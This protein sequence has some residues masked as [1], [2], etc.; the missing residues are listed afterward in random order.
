MPKLTY[1]IPIKKKQDR[2]SFH[3]STTAALIQLFH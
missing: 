1:I 3:Y 2:S